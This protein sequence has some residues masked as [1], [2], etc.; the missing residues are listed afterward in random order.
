M[1]QEL[2]KIALFDPVMGI[3]KCETDHKQM[4]SLQSFFLD[5]NTK[6]PDVGQ[7]IVFVMQVGLIGEH[8]SSYNLFEY[9]LFIT[10]NLEG[11]FLF[12]PHCLCPE[13]LMNKHHIP[14]PNCFHVC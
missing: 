6:G 9:S 13:I 1:G 8:L 2:S 4:H 12:L 10:Q 3:R 14:G 7:L 5:F 11:F